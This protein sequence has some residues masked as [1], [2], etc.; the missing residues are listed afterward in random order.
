[1]LI[2]TILNLR[3]LRRRSRCLPTAI[4]VLAD[5]IVAIP[6]LLYAQG[7][8]YW[9]LSFDEARKSCANY[10]NPEGDPV[11][12]RWA[13]PLVIVVWVMQLAAVAFG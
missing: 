2:L 6:V 4:N 7:A 5:G 3:S 13:V 12:L 8:F 9:Y 1:M 11:C 10:H